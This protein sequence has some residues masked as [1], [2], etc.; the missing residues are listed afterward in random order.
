MDHLAM[1]YEVLNCFYSAREICTFFGAPSITYLK[2]ARLKLF[3]EVHVCPVDNSKNVNTYCNDSC[4][5]LSSYQFS[6]ISQLCEG[7]ILHL[8]KIN[9]LRGISG[10][11]CITVA[12]VTTWFRVDA[13]SLCQLLCTSINGYIQQHDSRLQQ[14]DILFAKRDN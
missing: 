6:E 4:Q 9:A 5:S 13:T 14:Y 8:K 12:L 1:Q 2:F 11:Y 3:T 10:V 7:L